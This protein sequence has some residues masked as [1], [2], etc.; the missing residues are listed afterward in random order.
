MNIKDKIIKFTN[1][2]L[3]KWILE[4]LNINHS[5]LTNEYVEKN[6]LSLQVLSTRGA[7]KELYKLFKGD[8]QIGIDLILEIKVKNDNY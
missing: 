7:T 6:N 2:E 5:S 4:T 8:L 1:E 3:Q